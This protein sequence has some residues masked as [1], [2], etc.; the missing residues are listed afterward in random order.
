MAELAGFPYFEVQF[1]K[2]GE[3]FDPGETEAVLDAV[4]GGAF[5]VQPWLGGTY[6]NPRVDELFV[7]AHGWNNDVAEA[8]VF[9]RNLFGSVRGTLDEGGAPPL[10]GRSMA[11]LG[12]LWPSK[13]FADEDLIPGG[14]ASLGGGIE[15][16][17]VQRQLDELK[18]AF[19][20]PDEAA[21]EQ[22]KQLVPTLERSPQA[23]RRFVDLIRSV[24]P[25]PEDTADDASDTFFDL[26]G[27][28]VLRLLEPPILPGPTA[29]GDGSGAT[30]M[31]LMEAPRVA[32]V[33]G[34]VGIGDFFSGIGAAARRLLNYATYY[35]M[36]ERARQVGVRGL[37][38]LLRAIKTANPDVRVH[39]VGHSFG[40]RVV[41][42]AALGQPG[43]P[44]VAAASMTL[45][46]A[47]F[48]H[49]AFAL[50]FDGERDGFFRE[51]V[52]QGKVAGPILITHTKNDSAVGIAYPIASRI[53]RQDNADLGD[54]DDIF[55]G[56]GRNGAIHT[57][58]A[59][60]GELL[61]VGG[62]YAFAPGKLYN[63]RADA[64]ISGHSDVTGPAVA[65]ALL[66]AA[67]NG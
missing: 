8:R 38:P 21:L 24:L 60:A 59:G 63:L 29:G 42:A 48:S 35:Q 58:E 64:L 39:L 2:Q 41:A 47:A 19:D 33:G 23:Q 14:G 43:S 10:A 27:D 3:P 22:A 52:E 49:N 12:V 46:Q 36:K 15:D 6:D 30:G 51:V 56:I 28:E 31:G 18:G 67:S 65:Y 11:V 20:Q 17:A 5:G 4:R 61:P 16:R 9:Y 53:A 26:P 54:A 13:R 62:Q 50:R 45:L 34:A 40:G 55:G 44:S 7:V 57:P 66:T 37:H 25:R 1:T 32:P